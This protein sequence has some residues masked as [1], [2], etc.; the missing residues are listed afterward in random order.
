MRGK[1]MVEIEKLS[2]ELISE[3]FFVNNE[4]SFMVIVPGSK[5]GM[6]VNQNLMLV[7]LKLIFLVSKQGFKLR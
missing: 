1:A 4:N 2:I 3:V 5:H 7:I 6:T